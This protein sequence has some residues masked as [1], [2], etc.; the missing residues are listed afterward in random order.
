M[1]ILTIRSSYQ[2][3]AGGTKEEFGGPTW[4]RVAL[5][6]GEAFPR[7]PP[8]I[9]EGSPGNWIQNS[10]ERVL[11]ADAEGRGVMKPVT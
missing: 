10:G 11:P 1:K 5:S 7:C 2:P 6:V 8:Q 3:K 9:L 4:L